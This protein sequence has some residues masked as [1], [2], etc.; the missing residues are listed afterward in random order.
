MLLDSLPHG[1][2]TEDHPVANG[3]VLSTQGDAVHISASR[4]LYARPLQVHVR[5]P[6]GSAFSRCF[7]MKQRADQVDAPRYDMV[8]I[9]GS[10]I[11]L[12]SA[13]SA[14]HASA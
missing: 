2:R 9:F 8:V 6:F 11:G 5:G 12:P 1:G 3:V 7:E 10:G 4:A 14:L 13:L